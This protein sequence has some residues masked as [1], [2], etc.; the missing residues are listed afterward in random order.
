MKQTTVYYKISNTLINNLK[1]RK[2]IKIL[3]QTS[4][5]L[6]VTVDSIMLSTI[7]RNLISNAV[8]FS[9]RGGKVIVGAEEKNNQVVIYVQDNGIGMDEKMRNDVFKI[10]QKTTRKGTE[11]ELST[12]LGLLLCKE[13][14]EKHK[15]KISA[16]SKP[17]ETRFKIQLPYLN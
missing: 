1:H 14:V 3:N 8:K 17:G 10:D 13:F 9:N 7:I 4:R 16:T 11:K 15:G 12:G 6:E 2:D 5:N